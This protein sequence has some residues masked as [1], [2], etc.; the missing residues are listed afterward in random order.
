MDL[1]CDK[2][3]CP[4]CD[5]VGIK[6]IVKLGISGN[7]FKASCLTDC[8]ITNTNTELEVA[9]KELKGSY[10]ENRIYNRA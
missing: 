5:T 1:N 3:R 4:Q 7:M 10:V 6:I 9:I 2:W 8:L